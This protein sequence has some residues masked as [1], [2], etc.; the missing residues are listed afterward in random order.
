MW[1]FLLCNPR[2]MLLLKKKEKQYCLT[3]KY[4][5]NAN[6]EKLE[7]LFES[8]FHQ[9]YMSSSLS[10]R[11]AFFLD[12]LYILNFLPF[13]CACCSGVKKRGVKLHMGH[14]SHTFGRNELAISS[15]FTD[16]TTL[17]FT[18]FACGGD[19]RW[20]HIQRCLKCVCLTFCQIS[21]FFNPKS[22]FHIC[23]VMSNN[24]HNNGFFLLTTRKDE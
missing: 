12:T 22:I 23:T 13:L 2:H 6:D 8:I 7:F 21:F 11:S 14:I 5:R 4:L 1:V 15:H 3:W 17:V 10:K 24:R 20:N 16:N 18:V 19:C 9:R